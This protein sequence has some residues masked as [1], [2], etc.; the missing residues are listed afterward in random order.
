MR[1]GDRH[2]AHRAEAVDHRLDQGGAID[3]VGERLSHLDVLEELA[4]EIELQALDVIRVACADGLEDECGSFF[5]RSRS[6]SATGVGSRVGRAVLEGDRACTAIGH[7][8]KT[9]RSMRGRSGFQ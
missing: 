8:L 2:L 5:S 6:A 9:M 4:V 7:Q 1:P 3:G